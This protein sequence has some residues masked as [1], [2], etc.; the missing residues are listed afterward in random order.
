MLKYSFEEIARCEM[1]S[2]PTDNHKVLGQRLNQS[3]GLRP[4]SKTGISVSIKK[5]SDCNLIYASPMPIPNSIQDHYGIPPENYWIPEY[6]HWKPDYFASEI[7]NA[8]AILPFYEGMTALDI[9]AGIGK[10]MISM[11]NAGFNAYGLEPSKPFYD[12]AISNMKISPERLK[13]GTIEDIDYE[14]QSFDFITFG[15]VLEHLYHPAFCIEKALNWLKP[16]GLIHAEV[17]SSKHL[18]AK[19]LN[20]YFRLVG[21]NYVTHLSPMH[22]PFHLYEFGLESFQKLGVKLGYNV[23]AHQYM[24]CSTSPFPRILHPLLSKIMKKTDTGLQLVVWLQKP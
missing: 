5:C 19:I 6:F 13:F 1:C 10:C 4:K 16:G 22:V 18:L 21:T 11:E 17:P 3:Q 23:V 9:G 7:N 14:P 15:A 2:S 24:V 20:A 12:R 8:K